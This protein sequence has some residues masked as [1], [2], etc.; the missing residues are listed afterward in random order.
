MVLIWVE[1]FQ[2]G[3]HSQNRA[4][5]LPSLSFISS[6]FFFFLPLLTFLSLLT[7][8]PPLYFFICR[9]LLFLYLTLWQCNCL[10]PGL[11]WDLHTWEWVA[12][13]KGA[14]GPLISQ[15]LFQ[16][17]EGVVGCGGTWGKRGDQRNGKPQAPKP[18]QRDQALHAKATP[19]PS[20]PDICCIKGVE[21]HVLDTNRFFYSL[22]M[23]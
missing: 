10:I 18:W 14:G 20:A 9:H 11:T 12:A 7:S 16:S 1:W 5:S 15:D 23:G 3:S 17:F 4:L 21:V 2:H 19:E 8:H 6:C 22:R 13:K